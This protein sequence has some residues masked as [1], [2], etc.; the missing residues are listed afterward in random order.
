MGLGIHEF[1]EEHLTETALALPTTGA[2]PG[3]SVGGAPTYDFANIFQK[4]C[5]ELWKFWAVGGAP[6]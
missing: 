6:P 4:N 2:D 3:F 5:I 1:I